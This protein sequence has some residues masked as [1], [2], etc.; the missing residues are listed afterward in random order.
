MSISTHLNSRYF[1]HHHKNSH[2]ILSQHMQTHKKPLC[3]SA[4]HIHTWW[5]SS[6]FSH[7][8]LSSCKARIRAIQLWI[9]CVCVSLTIV[10]IIVDWMP[11]C[12]R[13]HLFVIIIIISSASHIRRYESHIIVS[14]SGVQK[15]K[16]IQLKYVCVR[17]S[18]SA[19]NAALEEYIIWCMQA[20]H[21]KQAWSTKRE[22]YD[23]WI[24]DAWL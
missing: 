21:S 3:H 5:T 1:H 6:F 19:K 18:K 7:L 16:N 2:S 12:A 24:D 15:N 10:I 20:R 22:L 23:N 8:A 13:R 17:S 4:S 9:V 11:P 14:Q